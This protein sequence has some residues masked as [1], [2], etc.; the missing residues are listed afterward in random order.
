MKN[1]NADDVARRVTRSL[2][3]G[4]IVLLHD[5]AES[6]DREPV[7]VRALPAILR[8]LEQRKLQ[9]VTLSELLSAA[10]SDDGA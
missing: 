6:D 8:E 7:I 5:A 1:S 2:S 4:A 3:G 9:A 10:D